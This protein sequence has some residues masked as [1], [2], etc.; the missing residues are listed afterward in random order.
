V[1]ACEKYKAAILQVWMNRCFVVFGCCGFWL[2]WFLVVVVFGC[3]GFW[4]LLF[5]V[6]VVFGCCCF[7]VVVVVWISLF[8]CRR[9]LSPSACI[10]QPLGLKDS[11][12]V[13]CILIPF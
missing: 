4:L 9:W 10:Y 6:V 5:L 3:C 8:F 11:E 7:L 1:L 12:D 13:I 2:L